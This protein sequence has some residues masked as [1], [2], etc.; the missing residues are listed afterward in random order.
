MSRGRKRKFTPRE[1]NGR[2]QRSTVAAL[3]AIER[4]KR[5]QNMSVVLSQPHRQGNTDQRCE[6]AL[7]RF[8]LKHRLAREIYDAAEEYRGV[9]NRWRAAKG[10]PMEL[11]QGIGSGG[12]GPSEDTVRGWSKRILLME[13]ALNR[14]SNEARHAVC[15][16]VLD[17]FELGAD[18][19]EHGKIGLFALAD[20]MGFLGNRAHPYEGRAA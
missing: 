13:R 12:D 19:V 17:G 2:A 6:S 8:C 11:R 9:V 15:Q 16:I 14:A 10:I 18:Q 20:E 3:E 1:P 4:D 5:L 7:G